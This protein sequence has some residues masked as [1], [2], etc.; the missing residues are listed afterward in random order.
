M[1]N[2]G[3]CRVMIIGAGRVGSHCA[4]SLIP[5]H[6]ADEIVLIDR[7]RPLAEAQAA[8]LYDFAT[9]MGSTVA[10]RAG[11]YEDCDDAS[12]VLI[13]AGRGRRATETRLELLHDT[14]EALRDIASRLS[15]TRFCG[16]VVCITN[17]VDVVTEYLRQQLDL[18]AGH[19]LGTGSALDTIRLRRMLAQRTGVDVAQIQGFCMGEHGDSSFVAWSH[20]SLGGVPLAEYALMHDELWERLDFG[21][22]QDEIHGT[23]AS[24]IAGKGCTEFGIGSVVTDIVR[25]VSRNQTRVLPLSAHLEGEYG[26]GDISIGVPCAI[27]AGGV[28]RVL[29]VELTEHEAKLFAHSCDVIRHA[30]EAK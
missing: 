20:V 15:H 13:A 21:E 17:P 18:P 10:V 11:S 16:V 19:V 25:A 28:Q 8:D 30:L 24:I 23:G 1:A 2:A 5:G 22:I 9:G 6:L 12:F 7:N 27:G 3:I 26:Q 29:E 14:L 4:M